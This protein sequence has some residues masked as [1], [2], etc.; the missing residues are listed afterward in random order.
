LSSFWLE[1]CTSCNLSSKFHGGAT[2]QA[3]CSLKAT[4]WRSMGLAKI[5]KDIHLEE[6]I[7][8]KEEKKRA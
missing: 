5:D 4:N 7:D 3:I 8:P 6:S 2:S 1:V